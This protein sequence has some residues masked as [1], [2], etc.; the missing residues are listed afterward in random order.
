MCAPCDAAHDA[1]HDAAQP[2]T[3]YAAQSAGFAPRQERAHVPPGGAPSIDEDMMP[4]PH[5]ARTFFPDRLA[6]HVLV[7]PR[8]ARTLAPP[9]PANQPSPWPATLSLTLTS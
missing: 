2:A 9:W 5:C 3:Q 1:G 4:C 8:R 6:K 7:R